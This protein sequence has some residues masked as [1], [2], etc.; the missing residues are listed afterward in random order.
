MTTIF[1]CKR[2]NY[3]TNVKC[4]LIRHLKK[5]NECYPTME[6]NRNDLLDELD[7]KTY[8][9]TFK[10]EYCNK[11]F[12]F[13]SNKSRH[14]N[15][16]KAKPKSS[17]DKFEELTKIVDKKNEKIEELEKTIMKQNKSNSKN[18]ELELQYYKN[19]KNEKFYQL[20]LENY[21]GGTHKT[22]SCGITDVTTDKCHAEIKEWPSWKEAVGQLTCYN[23]SD[24]KE[25]LDMYMFGKYTQKCKNEAIKIATS[26]KIN[27]YEFID[28][29]NGISI[30]S[31]KNNETI[32]NY[33]PE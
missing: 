2:C 10:C 6:Y 27:V 17:D 12:N 7:N 4:N 28:T 20:L 1:I 3:E 26:C 13:A 22:L 21:L 33:K 32:Y 15:I 19:R 16:C 23:V 18:L 11:L 25:R 5:D 9:D 30:I 29:D 24:P 8:K 31:L 14:K